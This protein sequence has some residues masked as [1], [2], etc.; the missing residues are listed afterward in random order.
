MAHAPLA[1]WQDQRAVVV[2]GVEPAGH[3]SGGVR[4]V[5]ARPAARRG[6][7]G[8]AQGREAPRRSRS[9]HL[10]AKAGARWSSSVSAADVEARSRRAGR[11]G[12]RRPRVGRRGVRRL[13]PIP[14]TSA[15]CPP[16]SAGSPTAC[17]R[18]AARHWAI[19]ARR[20]RPSPVSAPARR[21]APA[22][23][24]RTA[25]PAA[26][27]VS[28]RGMPG[29]AAK[30]PGGSV[31][32]RPAAPPGGLPPGQNPAGPVSPRRGARLR[33]WCCRPRPAPAGVARGPAGLSGQAPAP[34]A[35]PPH[36]PQEVEDP[37]H[38]HRRRHRQQHPLH[39]AD[40]AIQRLALGRR[41]TCSRRCAG[42]RRRR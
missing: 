20:R 34:P 3:G 35:R 28:S 17:R 10:S 13:T 18:S 14:M 21:A 29:D 27:A 16:V 24:R 25:A 15:P 36:R 11:R 6:Q 42:N 39:G 33:H 30:L 22:P 4:A 31:Q 5:T 19:S 41:N 38:H 12:E 9:S 8:G 2:D 37:Q 23:R 32:A 26:P 7:E 1:A 40:V